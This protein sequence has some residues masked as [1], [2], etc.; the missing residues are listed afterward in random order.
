MNFFETITSSSSDKALFMLLLLSSWYC[1]S[2]YQIACAHCH[3]TQS[4]RLLNLSYLIT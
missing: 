1:Q 4:I 2:C 3:Y